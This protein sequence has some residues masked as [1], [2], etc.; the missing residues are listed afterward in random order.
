MFDALL[1]LLIE[2]L[3]IATLADYVDEVMAH[4]RDTHNCVKMLQVLNILI[5]LLF[6][7]LDYLLLFIQLSYQGLNDLL[8]LL[9]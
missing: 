1:L 7:H 4:L 5:K 8:L 2:A 9:F 6:K 3:L